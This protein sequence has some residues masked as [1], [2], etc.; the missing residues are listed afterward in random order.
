M[1]KTLSSPSPKRPELVRTSD[2]DYDLP[3]ELIAQTPID[4]RDASRLLVLDRAADGL[5]HTAFGELPCLLRPGDLLVANNSRVLAARLRAE[6]EPTGGKVELLL[7]RSVE[8]G[9]WTALARPSR[10][11]RPGTDLRLASRAGDSSTR[12][13][14]E[15]VSPGGLV[16]VRLLPEVVS[17]LS[18]WGEV[19]LPPYVHQ[20]IADPERY[21]TIYATVDGS[22]AAPTA[23]LHFTPEVHAALQARGIAWA[24]VTL[25]VGLDTFRPV[26]AERLRD[27]KIHREWCEVSQE[28]VE[29]IATTR[30]AGG[31]V[32]AVGTTSAR[33][34][35]TLGRGWDEADPRAFSGFTDLYILPG[36]RWR[37][38]DGLLTN[39]HLPRTTLLAMVSALASWD[40]VRAAYEEAVAARYRFY[41]FG[42]AML[43]L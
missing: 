35:E 1:S 14:V 20:A 15:A 5:V 19:P 30:Q 4:R 24:E 38:V 41:S 9:S 2:L 42:D 37:L 36:H 39:F 8:P 13:T 40:R 33:T 3:P 26:T 27:H 28:T 34:L 6:K 31:R 29:R 25:H 32:I 16:T 22:V 7:L 23:G 12:L 11:L 18:D 21:Q 43:I 17:K 10:R